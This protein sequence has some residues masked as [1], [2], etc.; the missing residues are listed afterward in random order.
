MSKH[1]RDCASHKKLQDATLGNWNENCDCGAELPVTPAPTRAAL[2][3]RLTR[4]EPGCLTLTPDEH[5]VVAALLREP[6]PERQ[7]EL[8]TCDHPCV[9]CGAE[10]AEPRCE[11]CANR[12]RE[13]EPSNNGM[14]RSDR[15]CGAV[16]A[17][18]ENV[19]GR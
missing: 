6:E 14:S 9:D 2:A 11:D 10:D 4:W 1:T 16:P 13:P 7:V 3:E 12:L 19:N 18:T 15:E 8:E 5:L 17:P